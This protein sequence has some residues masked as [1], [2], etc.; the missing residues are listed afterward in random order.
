M[1]HIWRF[2]VTQFLLYHVSLN[3][4]WTN[5]NIQGYMTKTQIK[6]VLTTCIK[7]RGFFFLEINNN[8]VG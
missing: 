5:S 6:K 8:K 2:P 7:V 4:S 3:N 1:L